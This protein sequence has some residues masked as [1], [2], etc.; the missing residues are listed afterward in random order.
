MAGFAS[1]VLNLPVPSERNDAFEIV[2]SHI[3]YANNMSE[4][5]DIPLRAVLNSAEIS[6]EYS[7]AEFLINTLLNDPQKSECFQGK[8]IKGVRSNFF[9]IV[10][11]G[12]ISLH[13]INTDDNGAYTKHAIHQQCFIV[14]IKTC[15]PFTKMLRNYISAKRSRSTHTKK[16][17]FLKKMSLLYIDDTVKRRVFH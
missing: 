4:K 10:N 2:Y 8:A 7:K 13:N 5:L 3:K 9:H 15:A 12:E 16:L 6:K 14:T 1:Y 11:L 17:M